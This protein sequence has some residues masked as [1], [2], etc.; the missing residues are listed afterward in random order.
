MLDSVSKQMNEAGVDRLSA[1]YAAI[2]T[3]RRGGTISLIGVYGGQADPLPML[4][5]FES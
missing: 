3:V 1:F 5:L 2:H 4:I